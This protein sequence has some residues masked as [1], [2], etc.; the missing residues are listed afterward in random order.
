MNQLL[1]ERK[2]K[3]TYWAV[4]AQTPNPESGKLTHFLSRLE[5]HN[6][7]KAHTKKIEGAKEAVLDYH[8]LLKTKDYSLLEIAPKTG[9]Q[10]QIRVQLSAIGCPI[11]GDIKYGFK[12]PNADASICLHARRLEFIHPVSKVNVAIEAPVPDYP[13]WKKVVNN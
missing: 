3:K 5:N 4:V 11:V 6:I 10:H 13:V 12:E 2:V 9:R 8:L 7:T 1:K